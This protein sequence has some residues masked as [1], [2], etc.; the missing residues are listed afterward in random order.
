M[1]NLIEEAADEDEKDLSESMEGDSLLQ[2][3]IPGSEYKEDTQNLQTK[4]FEIKLVKDD[5]NFK[6][7]N[8]S[9]IEKTSLTGLK[10]RCMTED[11]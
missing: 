4:T 1:S 3:G 7:V 2:I 11:S 9:D 5:Q 10:L 6:S 8:L